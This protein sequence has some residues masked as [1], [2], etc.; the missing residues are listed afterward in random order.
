MSTKES[1]R[2]TTKQKST[3]KTLSHEKV[4]EVFDLLD[5]NSDGSI[6]TPECLKVRRRIE[7]SFRDKINTDDKNQKLHLR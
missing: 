3:Q 6:N 2:L 4:K 1:E 5:T 7:I